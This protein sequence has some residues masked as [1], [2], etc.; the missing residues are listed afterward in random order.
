MRCTYS[1]CHGSV[2]DRKYNRERKTHNLGVVY[3]VREDF[4]AGQDGTSLRQIERHVE[5]DFIV[6]LQ[7]SCYRER[8]N[9]E[10]RTVYF[11]YLLSQLHALYCVA[12]SLY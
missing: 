5:E 3:W 8:T 2:V 1:V 9:S 4:A 7:T 10:R 12:C 11:T 6:E